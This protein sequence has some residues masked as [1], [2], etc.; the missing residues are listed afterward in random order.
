MQSRIQ[1]TQR[2]K[3]HDSLKKIEI[4]GS[5]FS[6]IAKH[7]SDFGF[8]TSEIILAAGCSDFSNRT[9]TVSTLDATPGMESQTKYRNTDQD[10]I[11][12]SPITSP[13]KEINLLETTPIKGACREMD[14]EEGTEVDQTHQLSPVKFDYLTIPGQAQC[15]K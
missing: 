6:E 3:K 5:K 14:T 1:E 9:T 10:L 2:T 8:C 13:V 15:S 12:K 7:G 4:N 11:S